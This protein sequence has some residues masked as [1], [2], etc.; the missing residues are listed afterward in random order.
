[1]YILICDDNSLE[2]E[3]FTNLIND[4]FSDKSF[5]YDINCYKNGKSLLYDI[6]DGKQADVIF[7]DVY[8]DEILGID[9]A[10]L[11]RDMGYKGDIVFI[12]GT[13][14]FAIDGYD[15]GATGYLLKPC[16]YDK[17]C[18]VMDRIMQN[19]DLDLYS[20]RQRNSVIR[21]KLN[22][23]LYVESVN[24]KCIL[25]SDTGENYI[26]YKRLNEIQNELND[27]RFLRCHQSYLVNMNHIQQADKN[28]TLNNG[29]TVNIRQ[30]ELKNI[31]E[32]YFDY[33]K[34]K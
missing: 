29:D 32:L 6:E 33:I 31:K 13:A 21:L 28:F 1:M 8:M 12:T 17:L 24:S 9:V 2:R 15:V 3:I 25:H 30:R 14:D 4:Y 19:F 11:L 20:I 34:E 7:L 27:D 16:S 26:I 22:S 5:N 23:I 10:R 18:T